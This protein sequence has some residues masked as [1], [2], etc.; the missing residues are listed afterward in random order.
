MVCRFFRRRSYQPLNEPLST[1]SKIYLLLLDRFVH[2]LGE[3]TTAFAAVDYQQRAGDITGRFRREEEAW[4]GDFLD[5]AE[6][7]HRARSPHHLLDLRI[8]P[9]ARRRPFGVDRA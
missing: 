1:W 3:Q 9:Y 6:T 8:G 2:L 5:A 4:I 7:L